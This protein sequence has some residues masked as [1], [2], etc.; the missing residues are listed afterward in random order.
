MVNVRLNY[1]RNS[2]VISGHLVDMKK[3]RCKLNKFKLILR[4]NFIKNS[5]S[6]V[7]CIVFFRNR[8]SGIFCERKYYY[9]SISVSSE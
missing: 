3:L 2:R 8:F 1:E 5:S 9:F 6:Y 7:S 4:K